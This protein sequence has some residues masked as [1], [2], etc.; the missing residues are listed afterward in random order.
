MMMTER[1]LKIRREQ[2]T[3]R[4]QQLES[5]SQAHEQQAVLMRRETIALQGQVQLIN[6]QLGEVP[7][8]PGAVTVSD[9]VPGGEEIKPKP[10]PKKR[11]KA[12]PRG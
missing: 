3:G 8:P 10:R 2:I 5:E 1:E 7:P 12:V 9:D 4:I 6:E 11:G